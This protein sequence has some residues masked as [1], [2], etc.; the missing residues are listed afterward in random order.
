[1][2]DFKWVGNT[3]RNLAPLEFCVSDWPFVN[4]RLTVHTAD[5]TNRA[6]QRVADQLKLQGMFGGAH[7]GIGA[8]MSYFPCACGVDRRLLGS[9]HE[10]GDHQGADQYLTD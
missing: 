2:S 4:A 7:L 1:M 6:S 8:G 3:K 5:V 9:D 10:A